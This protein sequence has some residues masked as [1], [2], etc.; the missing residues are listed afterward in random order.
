MPIYSISLSNYEGTSTVQLY[1]K[2][3]F[4]KEE[5][6]QLYQ[7]VVEQYFVEFKAILDSRPQDEDIPFFHSFDFYDRTIIILCESYQFEQIISTE[8]IDINENRISGC[9]ILG[10]KDSTGQ[11]IKPDSNHGLSYQPDV[12]LTERSWKILQEYSEEYLKSQGMWE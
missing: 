7:M 3:K 5:F 10:N 12:Y 9:T 1:H 11:L 6:T 8:Y 4:T 2:K